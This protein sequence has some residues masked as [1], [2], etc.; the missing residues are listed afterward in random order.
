MNKKLLFTH[1]I[2]SS[3]LC[4][5]YTYSHEQDDPLLAS[6]KVDKLE[7]SSEATHLDMNAWLGKDINKLWLKTDIT[8]HEGKTEHA[9]VQALFSHAFA[10]YWDVQTGIRRDIRPSPSQTWGVIGV[11]GLAPYFFEIDAAIFIGEAGRTAARISADYDLL[12]TQRLIL[13]PEI[14]IN[15]YGQNDMATG[16]GSGVSNI[17]TGLRLRYEIRREFAPYIGLSWN[18]KLGNTAD[19]AK[20]GNEATSNT[21]WIIGIRAWF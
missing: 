21:E 16:T 12:F 3:A 17:S 1:I 9:E 20:T 14:E 7:N 13:A 19:F 11:Q 2:F 8:Q 6:I 4:S 18:K 5:S 10:P 15:A